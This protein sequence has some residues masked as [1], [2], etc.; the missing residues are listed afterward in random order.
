M[1]KAAI[2][3]TLTMVFLLIS[4]A[5]TTAQDITFGGYVRNT[6]GVFLNDNL[7][8]S[9]VQNTLDFSAE[10]YG[11]IGDLKADVYLNQSGKNEI[12]AGVKELYL[13][14]LLDSMD[15][16]IG[17]QQIIWGK[18]DGV[19][20]TDVVSPK[21]LSNFILPDFDEIRMGVTGV[22]SDIYLGPIVFELVWLPTFTPAVMPSGIWAVPMT[23]PNGTP[24]TP[25]IT[26]PSE[27]LENSEYFGKLSYMGSAID[28]ELMGAYMWDDLPAVYS[29]NGSTFL[30]D[31]HRVAMAGGSFSTDIAGLVFKGEGAYYKGKNFTVQA[32][33]VSI[34]EK[35]FVNYMVGLDYSI[36]G[37]TLGTQFIQEIVLDYDDRIMLND[38]L[39]NTMTFVV[40]KSFLNDTLMVEFFSYVGLS[41]EDAL[42]RPKVTYDIA[43]GLEWV[44]GSDIFLGDSGN[45]GQYADNDLVYTKLKYSF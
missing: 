26:T 3:F 20:I 13:D 19:F 40:A 24:I 2:I 11:D 35:D 37:Y 17:K 12:K 18:A 25:T 31:Y 38:E 29:P 27:T 33:P 14:I 9:Q 39:K 32:S 1:K 28:V 6:T 21:N 8:F 30:G 41:N 5:G 36:G 4:A 23:L 16:R 15:F 44:V 10:Y 42:L 34:V 43:D 7:D 45:F 22:K